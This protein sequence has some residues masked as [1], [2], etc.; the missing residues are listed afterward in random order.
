VEA[1]HWRERGRGDLSS[2]ERV[3][4]IG[5]LQDRIWD[6]FV[7]RLGGGWGVE[8]PLTRDGDYAFR[9]FKIEAEGTFNRWLSGSVGL[10]HREFYDGRIGHRDSGQAQVWLKRNSY[11]VG[12]GYEK[13]EEITNEFGLFQGTRSDNLWLGGVAAVN[14]NLDAEARIT[15]TEYSDGN[16][17]MSVLLR[18]AYA[19]TDHPRI[20]KTILTLGYRDTDR[21]TVFTQAGDRIVSMIHPYWTPQQY[22][23]GALTL[24]WYH[25]LA[26]EYFVGSA[27]HFYDLRLTFGTDSES[28]DGLT[29][30]AD[31][32]REWKNRWIGHAGFYLS[33][34]EQ[35]D[36]MG[37]NLQLIRRF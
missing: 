1:R 11:G 3:Q 9:A 16:Q 35:W 5:M 31:W 20:F 12:L 15:G 30:E 24:E 4:L 25:D 37:A 22:A 23:S 2:I 34:T 13:R 26:R 7:L 27:A 28:N 29:F 14:R 32:E 8:M 18:P 6:R 17:G 19:W 33:F 21:A 36:A 10:L